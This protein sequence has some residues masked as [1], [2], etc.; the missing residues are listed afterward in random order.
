MYYEIALPVRLNQQFTYKSDE[1]ILP[2]CRVVVSLGNAHHTGIVWQ[3]TSEIDPGIRY[4][5][6]MEI[7]DEHPKLSAESMKLAEWISR[8][9]QCS[10]GQALFAMLPAAF[11]INIQQQVRKND[12]EF[13]GDMDEIGHL[14]WAGLDDVTWMD[15]SDL[16]EQVK[17]SSAAIN[18]CLERFED[19]NLIEIKRVYDAKIK[20]KIANFVVK[21]EVDS[22]PK[23][24]E[25]QQDLYNYI[26]SQEKP[27]PLADTAKEFSYAIVK[28]L[29]NKDLIK[30]EPRVLQDEQLEFESVPSRK[31]I[32][33]TDEQNFAITKINEKIEGNCFNS[34]LLFGITGSGKTEVYIQAIKHALSLNKTA[35]MLVPEISLTPQMV[36]RFYNAFGTEIAILHSHLNERERW[37]QWK[38]IKSGKCKIVIGARSAIFAPL[39]NIG[40]IIVDEEHETSYKQESTP[41]YNGR[42]VA[43]VRARNSN[44]VVILGSATPSLETWQNATKGR[45]DLLRLTK[46]PTSFNLPEVNIVDM[47]GEESKT[48]FSPLLKDKIQEK[49]EAGEQVILFQNRRGHSSFVQCVTC[50]KMFTCKNCEIS[51]NYHNNRKLICHYCGHNHDMPRKCPDCGGYIFNFGSPGTQQ[52]EIQLKVIF[53]QARILRMDSD[54]TNKKESYEDM[55]RDMRDGNIDIL[56]GTQMIAK[57]LDFPNVTLVGVIAAD[58]SLNLPDFRAAERTFQLLTQVAGRSGRGDKAGEVIIQTYNPDHYAIQLAM[59][60]DYEKFAEAELSYRKILKYPP[61]QRLARFLFTSKDLTTLRYQLKRNAPLFHSLEDNYQE[62]GLS[63][64]GPVETPLPKLQNNFRFH[65]ILKAEN[66]KLLSAAVNY[67]RD[68]LNLGSKVN[69]AIDIDPMSLL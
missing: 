32:I 20:K 7:V 2:G 17:A 57:G 47:K 35:L 1:P 28:A 8:Y 40:I 41:R 21:L 50:G 58:V 66:V 52:V 11:N 3:E 53:P 55:F 36:S 22:V 6:I 34:F 61:A 37:I 64:L 24:T 49:I 9:Y 19:S 5:K 18:E 10:L 14:V 42:D 60:Q 45:Y 4:K 29:R 16:K 54:T 48:M 68:N 62:K 39:D 12:K 46:R 65:L 13:E 25:K 63:V 44:A 69:F 27:F 15:I 51:L 26:L 23:L 67:L 59:A 56:L 33:F 30:I 43:I 31:E 38:N